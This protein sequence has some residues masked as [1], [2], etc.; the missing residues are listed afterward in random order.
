MRAINVRYERNEAWALPVFWLLYLLSVQE[1]PG[2][3]IVQ[4]Y[5]IL[6]PVPGCD[7]T[8]IGL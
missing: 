2:G 5:P 8:N 4:M 7:V 3:A 6:W 1:G